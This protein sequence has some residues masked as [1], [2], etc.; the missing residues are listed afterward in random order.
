MSLPHSEHDSFQATKCAGLGWVRAARPQP[1][2]PSVNEPERVALLALQPE[3]RHYE[4]SATWRA[5]SPHGR[6]GQRRA[7]RYGDAV[8]HHRRRLV[9][10]LLVPAVLTGACGTDA[11]HQELSAPTRYG[12][13]G[14]GLLSLAPPGNQHP[15]IEKSQ[16]AKEMAHPPIVPVTHR[17]MVLPMTLARVTAGPVGVS[18]EVGSP[19]SF[20]KTLAWV[21]VY[22]DLG[23]GTGSCPAHPVNP[24]SLP[25]L[26][27]HYYFAYILDA[28][29][30][31]IVLWSEDESARALRNCVAH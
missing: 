2:I 14:L 21:Q 1:Q 29:S 18:G 17:R 3:P 19:T 5:E 6:E 10:C 12:P 4:R 20:A 25:P 31:A 15:H 30:G 11:G 16:A 9:G 23:G 7:A 27:A 22:E 24:T 26:Q 28:R 8:N 13:P